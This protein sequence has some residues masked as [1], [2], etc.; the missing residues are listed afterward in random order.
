M[1]RLIC[2]DL[3]GTLLDDRF[4]LPEKNREAILSVLDI[5][6]NVALVSG[7]PYC[8]TRYFAEC[9]SDRVYPIGTN[10]TYFRNGT[11]RYGKKLERNEIKEILDTVEKHDLT[12]QFKGTDF[13][14]SNRH[15][16]PD[17]Q[18]RLI[19]SR[20]TEDRQMRI[21]ETADR[22][23]IL[24]LSEEGIFKSICFNRDTDKK[25]AVIKAKKELQASNRFEVV[26]SHV[27]NFEVMKKG[28]SKG[29]AV[30]VLGSLLGI[31]RNEIMAI[32]DNENDL[33]MFNAAGLRIAM[34][35][36][37]E[38]LKQSSD[39]IVGTN[40]EAGVAEAIRNYCIR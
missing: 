6:I 13:M 9:I 18:Y 40:V 2:I 37:S 29:K 38:E 20:V 21:Y 12:I 5:G 27:Q 16:E 39:H 24:N 30:E 19:N 8:I 10:G 4:E 23:T 33:S 7:R 14:T 17:H 36:A 15:V 3:D 22:E 34:G 28:T 25:D 35:N 11:M 26:S 31:S 1:I 32:G